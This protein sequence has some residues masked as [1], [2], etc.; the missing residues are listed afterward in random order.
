MLKTLNSKWHAG[1]KSSTKS[2]VLTSVARSD[3]LNQYMRSKT[4]GYR[5]AN[6]DIQLNKQGFLSRGLIHYVLNY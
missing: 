1:D 3:I 5:V 2:W 6:R 4:L